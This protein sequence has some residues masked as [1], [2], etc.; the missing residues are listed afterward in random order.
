MTLPTEVLER[1]DEGIQA[2]VAAGEPEPTSMAL[3]TV[4]ADGKASVRTVL[5]KDIDGD[6][7]VFY[8]NTHSIK[9]RQLAQ[10]PQAALCVLWKSVF[11]QV[12]IEGVTHLV[13]NEE[14]DA[15]FASRPRGSQIGAWAS[16][17]SEALASRE[18]LEQRVAEFE[19]KFAGKTVPRPPHWSGYRLVP[20]MVEFWYGREDRL[21]DRFRF[22]LTGGDWT[23]QR[24]YP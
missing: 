13:P 12:L 7:M 23:R 2:A 20:D 10:H 24:L 4:A 9:G 1:F 17:Q 19:R 14:A 6:G 5:L 11:R 21:H 8:T 22:T 15:Y 18:L 16:L 3:A